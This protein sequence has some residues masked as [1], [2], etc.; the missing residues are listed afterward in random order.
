MAE[1][2]AEEL[3]KRLEEREAY[4]K[5]LEKQI[6]QLKTE[7][8]TLKNGRSKGGPSPRQAP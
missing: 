3:K 7:N 4:I 6:A 2:E 5:E 1:A 8:E